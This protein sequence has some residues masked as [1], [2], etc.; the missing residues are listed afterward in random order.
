MFI[1]VRQYAAARAASFVGGSVG[2]EMCAEVEAVVAEVEA[3]ATAQASGK[4]ASREGTTLKSVARE[5]LRRTLTTIRDTARQMARTVPGLEEKFRLPRSAS[6]QGWLAVARAF[7]QDAAP[8]KAEFVR[9]GLPADFLEELDAEITAYEHS[10]DTRA[11]KTGERV[12]ATAA[13]DA[14]IERGM[15][16]VRA[17]DA[18]VRNIFRDDPAAL[19]EW[20][21]ASH[22]ER[23][24]RAAHAATPPAQ[25]SPA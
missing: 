23:S 11:Q 3:R 21:S 6:D 16:A 19:A 22:T 1:R 15:N 10:I 25:P 20:T 7:A 12:A 14:A 4:H 13:I 9:W 5:T 8:L 24:P 18:I 17:L 2:K